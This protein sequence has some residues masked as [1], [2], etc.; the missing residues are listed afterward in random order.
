M[1]ANRSKNLEM[2]VKRTIEAL[3]KNHI[4][5]TFIPQMEDVV[6]VVRSLMEKGSSCA[7][8]GSVSLFE[9]KV[10]DLLKSGDYDFKNRYAAK[11]Q[12]ELEATWYASFTVDTFLA[13]ANAVT[14]HGELYLVDGRGTRIAPVIFGPKQVILICSTD[15]IVPD[16][17]S[18]VVR[19]KE[20]AAPANVLHFDKNTVCAKKGRCMSPVCDSRNLMALSAGACEQTICRSY[21]VLSN[22]MIPNRI[23]VLFVPQQIGY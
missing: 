9:S 4:Q 15:K 20:V 5:A 19:V 3:G 14:E 1:D 6:P 7:V 2:Q 12:E 22:Q 10:I 11:N 17:A 16:L 8:G 13:S 23:K 18:A 21:L